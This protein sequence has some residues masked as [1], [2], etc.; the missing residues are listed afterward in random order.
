MGKKIRTVSTTYT[1][2]TPKLGTRPMHPDTIPKFESRIASFNDRMR[3]D[4]L[5]HLSAPK[6]TEKPTYKKKKP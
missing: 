5:G 4:S 2:T 6:M 3:A 1:T